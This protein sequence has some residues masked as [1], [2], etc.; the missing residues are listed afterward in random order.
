M[1]A[2]ADTAFYAGLLD[3]S[4]RLVALQMQ[5]QVS[6]SISA[7]AGPHPALAPPTCLSQLGWVLCHTCSRA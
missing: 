2:T 7:G 1:L 4:Q 6:Q 3:H 5:L